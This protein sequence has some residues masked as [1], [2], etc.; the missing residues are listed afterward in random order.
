[1]KRLLVGLCALS[2]FAVEAAPAMAAWDS[3]FQAT[4][5]FHRRKACSV[6]VPVQAACCPQPVVAASPPPAPCCQ[7]QPCQQCTTQYVQRCFYQP[8]TVYQQQSYYEP[9]TTYRTSYYYEPVCSYR[10]ACYYDP[11]TCT[12]RQVA[13]P[14]TSYVLRAQQC[15]VQSWVQ[16]CCSVPVTTYQKS[17]YLEPHTTCCQTTVGALIPAPCNG[18]NGSGA[19]PAVM[20]PAMMPPVAGPQPGPGVT[21]QRSMT[22]PPPPV[23]NEQRTPGINGTGYTPQWQP[24]SS[25]QLLKPL[26]PQSPQ[27]PPPPAVKLDRIVVGPDARI[28]GQVVRSDNTPRANAQVLFVRADQQGVMQPV[29]ANSVGRFQTNLSTGGWLVYLTNPD[30]T[31][32]Y[33]SRIEVTGEQ[34]PQIVLTSR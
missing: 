21:E 19:P 18:C 27:S 32:A 2:W 9:V 15:P 29:T 33:H 7:P 17:C 10:Y 31:Q 13:I 28:E 14:Q 6:P 24:N 26:S 23:I 8:V 16:R 4:C 30:G 34:G 5:F 12:S 20:P 1:M 11:C 22:P 25:P 3:V